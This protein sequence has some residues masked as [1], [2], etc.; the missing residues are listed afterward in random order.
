MEALGKALRSPRS[1]KLSN[2]KLTDLPESLRA[3]VG[4]LRIGQPSMPVR[5][6][7]G[8]LVLM[9]CEKR[10]G[11]PDPK[12]RRRIENLLKSQKAELIARRVLRNLRRTAFIDIRR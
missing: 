7:G 12:L 2:V 8:V 6:Q 9:V 4:K 1:G 3:I 11:G 10:G 5:T